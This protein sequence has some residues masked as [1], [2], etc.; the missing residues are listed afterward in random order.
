M[1]V[2]I[3]EKQKNI[4]QYLD[5]MPG[6]ILMSL[7]DASPDCIKLIDQNDALIYINAKGRLALEIDP[8]LDLIGTNWF[9]L[10][11]EALHPALDAAAQ[12]VRKGEVV[13]LESLCPTTKGSPRWW[14]V[15][16]I[17]VIKAD[18]SIDHIV[19]IARDITVHVER[20]A[21]LRSWHQQAQEEAAHLSE[22]LTAK[23]DELNT[24][25]MLI[26]ES[27]HRIKNSLAMI[28]SVLRMQIQTTEDS[29]ARQVLEDAANR[30]LTVGQVHA[31]L[32]HIPEHTQINLADYLSGLAENVVDAMA[33]VN[34]QLTPDMQPM[35]ED[36]DTALALGLILTELI[37][38]ALRHAF[39]AQPDATICVKLNHFSDGKT[40]LAVV[41][42]GRGLDP[43]FRFDR[44]PSLG[45]KIIQLYAAKLGAH[46]DISQP[47]TGGTRFEVSY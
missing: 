3:S 26:R 5:R 21:Q 17:P 11:P 2:I 38:N 13:R 36:A 37:S 6:H 46:I 33:S 43:G 15:S 28:S 4:I 25:D 9:S 22:A 23:Q 27:D 32:H 34:V 42:N 1:S 18:D 14:D 16:L 44:Q 7:F 45:S 40:C 41:D 31:Q 12:R 47:G 8:E 19:S 10:I 35:T 39:E 20:A 24:Q 30:I 29:H